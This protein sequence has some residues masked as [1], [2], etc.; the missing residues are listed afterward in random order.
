MLDLITM[1][2]AMG[3]QGELA[4]TQDKRITIRDQEGADDNLLGQAAEALSST[5]ES[6]EDTLSS[7]FGSTPEPELTMPKTVD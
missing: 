3:V 1:I 4:E 2:S 5:F 7:M 6:F